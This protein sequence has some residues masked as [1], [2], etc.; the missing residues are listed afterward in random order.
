MEYGMPMRLSAFLCLG[1]LLSLPGCGKTADPFASAPGAPFD[2]LTF[3]TGHVRSWGVIEDRGGAPTG[4]VQTDCQGSRTGNGSLTMVQHLSLPDGK[5]QERGW[6][7]RQTGPGTYEATANDMDGTAEGIV[8]GPSFHWQWIW[9]R[10]P[11][12]PL[13]TVLMDQWMYRS[14]DGT[15]MIRT[16]I[17]K[18]GVILAEVSEHF[19]HVDAG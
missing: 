19:A 8:S 17:S 11:N 3:F 18:L 4:V 9:A 5:T 16:T 12:N 7:M 2:P 15:V 14:P 1:L 6:T 13:S 10:S